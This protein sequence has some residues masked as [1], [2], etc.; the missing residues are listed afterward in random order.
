VKNMP[1]ITRQIAQH[2]AARIAAAPAL[3]PQTAEGRT[4]LVDALMR[5]CSDAS[6]ANAVMTELLDSS[7][8]PVNLIAEIAAIAGRTRRP[9]KP[10]PGCE[11]CCM[12]EDLGTKTITW[13]PY[14]SVTI[15]GYECAQ[16][17]SCARGAW[18]A[19]RDREREQER[20]IEHRPRGPIAA[21]AM[22][23]VKAL[24]A[25]DRQ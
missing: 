22:V 8:N 19:E 7:L 20:E 25:G 13:L 14:I 21:G 17:C 6:H 18:L 15:R 3:L 2:V 16:R 24:S 10:P 11:R 5:H 4:E 9:D 12:G 23:D 1:T